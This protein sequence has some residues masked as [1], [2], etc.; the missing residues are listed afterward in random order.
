[1][2]SV[3]VVD[4]SRELCDIIAKYLSLQPDMQIC[5]VC[6]DGRSAVNLARELRPELVL[7]DLGL[8]LLDGLGVLDALRGELP[9][10]LVIT[11][12]P[13]EDIIQKALDLGASYCLLKP[14]YLSVLARTIRD[15]YSSS[16]EMVMDNFNLKSFLDN[17][18]LARYIEDFLTAAGIRQQLKGY[19]YLKEALY[20][21]LDNQP[22]VLDALTKVL[23]PALAEKFNTTPSSVEAAIR[24]A[25]TSAWQSDKAA[26]AKLM[27]KKDECDGR[28]K[29]TTSEFLTL[30]RRQI[31][32]EL[33]EAQKEVLY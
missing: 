2:I 27:R 16:T 33:R 19:K 15:V 26:L 29:P 17:G 28:K 9:K 14:F 18:E 32:V 23:Y 31:Q 4:H 8:P 20:L 12:F 21:A 1:M 24:G 5:G 13:R 3:L 10:V 6:Y 11:A 25:I 22:L 7:L 30:A